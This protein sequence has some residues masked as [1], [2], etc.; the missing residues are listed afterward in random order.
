MIIARCQYD[1]PIEHDSDLSFV[2]DPGVTKQSDAK[3]CDINAIFKKYEK[4]GQ[5]P[6]MILKDGTYGDFSA[7]PDYQEALNIVRHAG[8]QFGALDVNVRNRFENN[9]EKFLEFATNPANME[10]M[11]RM[12]LLKPEIL[13]QR[14]AEREAVDTAARASAEAARVAAERQLIDKIKA[15][16]GR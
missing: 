8:E 5:L 1:D 16:L 7:V 3:D 13:A 2:D 14:Q 10:E 4:S 12:G 6:D 15:E 11:G 9:P